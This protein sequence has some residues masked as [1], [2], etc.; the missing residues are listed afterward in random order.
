[1][2]MIKDPSIKYPRS[3]VYPTS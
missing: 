2:L 1:M 3:S